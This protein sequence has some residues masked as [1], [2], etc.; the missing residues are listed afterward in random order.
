MSEVTTG[1]PKAYPSASTRP[2]VA[3]RI[4][5]AWTPEMK[6]SAR[7]RGLAF[8]LDPNWRLMIAE[9]VSGEKNP[10]WEDGRAV[11]PYSPGFAGKVRQLVHERDGECCQKCGSTKNLCVHH[12]DFQKNDHDLGN[13]VLLCRKCHTGTHLEHKN[14]HV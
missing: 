14:G 7:L 8:A 11:L 6:E 4:R 1:K 2:E 9:S 5:L 12:M 10:R 3:E 13:L